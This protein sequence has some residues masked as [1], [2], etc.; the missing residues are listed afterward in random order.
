M[1]VTNWRRKLA[2]TLVAG[3]LISPSAAYAANLNTN[4]V[5]D[6]QFDMLTDPSVPCCFG[7]SQLDSWNDGTQPG[8]AYDNTVSL[9]D[10]GGPLAGG[11]THYFGTAR[12]TGEALPDITM[13]GMVSENIDVS[14]GATLAQID[15]GEAVV[16][17]SAFFTS[18]GQAQST[19]NTEGDVGFVHVDF[20]NAGA[21]SLGT[22]QISR[23]QPTVNGW[24]QNSG[25]F[26]I[27]VGA[28][29]LKVS[30][31]G[32][33][34]TTGPDG[35]IDIVDVQVR[36]ADDELLFLEVNTTTGQTAIKNQSGDPLH[37]DFYEI[38]SAG[39]A[40]KAN[41]WSSLQDQ[42][43]PGFPAGNGAG[44]GWEENGGSSAGR[45]GESYL[46]GNS[47]IAN[48]ANVDLGPAFKSA[49]AHDLVFKYGVAEAQPLSAD[50][51][52]DGDADGADFLRWQRGLGTSGAGATMAVGNADG[53]AD[54][55]AADLAIWRSEFGD[56]SF[57]GPSKLVTGFVR[58]VTGA[59]TAVPE[60][61]SVW[62]VGFG[63]ASVAG[64]GLRKSP[65][66][67]AP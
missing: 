37:I 59:A 57:S 35:Y 6:P 10:S 36:E 7:Q 53:D 20:L 43:L 19:R 54:V 40:L 60:P 25:A 42:N 48:G 13:P 3:G 61:A 16:S 8:F 4:L 50:F 2:A 45:L 52:N 26:L 30:L 46:A 65:R 9:Y 39:G 32:A 51:D 24:N 49:G 22:A 33:A 64:R 31:Y 44:N 17:L 41:T 5:P 27:P 66:A 18:Y 14:T 63:L 58:Y 21:S 38:T 55:D 11:G 47:L 28:R 23:R 15:S 62:L 34:A 56:T 67:G 29:T 1:K 12:Y